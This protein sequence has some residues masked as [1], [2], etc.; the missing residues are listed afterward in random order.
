MSNSSPHSTAQLAGTAVSSGIARGT[1]FVCACAEDRAVSRRVIA[2]SEIPDELARLE[3]AVLD[4]E[5]DLTAL[6]N[7]LSPTMADGSAVI[8]EAEAG[9][10]RD[11]LLYEATAHRCRTERLNVEAA[12]GD[13]A[14]GLAQGFSQIADP[15]FRER[16]TDV[17]D[18]ARRILRRLSGLS[19]ATDDQPPAGSILVTRELL[20]S[21]AAAIDN[22][23]IRGIIAERGAT[24]AH[25][26]ILAR[27]LG[28][29]TVIHV[30]DAT[31]K[32]V[33]GDRLIVDGLSGRVF[34]N[35]SAS[36]EREYDDVESIL[37]DRTRQLHALIDLPAITQDGAR[38]TLNA[39][40]GKVADASAAAAFQADAIGLYRTEF[41]FFAEDHLPGEQ[42]QY[43]VYS[44]AAACAA[45]RHLVVRVL[46]I[47][48]D[49]L[50][51]YFPLPLEA[52]PS[53][54]SRG[55]RLLLRH[56]TI[57]T[58]QLRAILRLSATSPVSLLFPMVGG[59][60]EI[61]EVKALIAEV[62]DQLRD[63]GIPFDPHLRIGAMI[64]TPAAAV[65]AR[66]IAQEVDFLSVGTN[67]LVQYL[68][69]TDRTNHDLASFYEPLH[70]AV[71]LTLKSVLDAAAAEGKEISLCGEIAGNPTYTELL[72]G[73]GA[74]SLSVAPGELLEIK[75]I[76]RSSTIARAEALANRA[77]SSRT[78]RD[79]KQALSQSG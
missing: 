26:V 3:R 5:T 63:E 28:I 14:D 75:L 19:A 47:G 2:E 16:A 42:E 7:K 59:V 60:E 46:D 13:I 56:R 44:K 24:T 29:P 54:G 15:F 70:P 38:I 66:H 48:S 77:L 21:V 53:L 20:P 31:Q 43:A 40:I 78:I 73:L 41:A 68:L 25:A 22:E 57:F 36:V 67:D 18:V 71:L 45:G 34:A 1:A 58:A 27:A 72:L 10:L 30:A 61:C 76:I 55:T 8:L 11:P 32:L 9:L 4:V 62:T 6:Q 65:M 17:K 12:L 35:P 74:R 52:N 51:P 33:T 64:E 50:L 37:V 79:V 69:T 39:N 23:H 49:K